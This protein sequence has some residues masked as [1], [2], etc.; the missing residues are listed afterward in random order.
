MSVC[1]LVPIKDVRRAKTRLR[2][3][4]SPSDTAFLAEQMANLTVD[5]LTRSTLVERI[6][7]MGST[8]AVAKTAAEFGCEFV[9]EDPSLDNEARVLVR[10][11]HVGLHAADTL[12]ILPADIP[13]I[14]GPDIDNLIEGHERGLSLCPASRDGGTN[15]LLI[16]PPTAIEFQFGHDS[17][18]RHAETARA[19]GLPVNIIDSAVFSRDIDTPEDL[20]WLSQ[21][22]RA[23]P[24][25]EALRRR[26]I[27]PRIPDSQTA[28]S[29]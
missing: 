1:A 22:L 24:L 16:T 14:T 19:A 2:A 21:A 3:V 26:G 8:R 10:A 18:R 28:L 20:D 12:A 25:F 17:A 11:T 23:G 13:L 5:A 4:L 6:V 29:A 27:L 7:L 15:A 9:S